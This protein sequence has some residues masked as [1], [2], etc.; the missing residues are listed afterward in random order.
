VFWAV[1][2][3]LFLGLLGQRLASVTTGTGAMRRLPGF[4]LALALLAAFVGF[5]GRW[6]LSPSNGTRLGFPQAKVPYWHVLAGALVAETDPGD[7]VVAPYDISQWVPVYR[8]HPRLAAVRSMYYGPVARIHPQEEVAAR[9][10]MVT[11]MAFSGRF[12]KQR[13][14]AIVAHGA[15]LGARFMVARIKD[16]SPALAPGLRAIGCVKLGL[17]DA[18]ITTLFVAGYEVWSCDTTQRPAD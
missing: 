16:Q 13:V 12:T 1:P 15:S 5:G 8:G 14:E 6:T 7:L 2:F 11:A 18:A 9:M 17:D 4:A 3:P 10:T